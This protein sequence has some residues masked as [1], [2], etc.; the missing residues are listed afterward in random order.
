M[1]LVEPISKSGAGWPTIAFS[2]AVAVAAVM[3][4]PIVNLC[5]EPEIRFP[6]SLTAVGTYTAKR[7][8]N[9][10]RFEFRFARRRL[11]Q[12]SRVW[13]VEVDQFSAIIADSMIVPLSFPVVTT[14]AVAK[15]NLIHQPGLPQEPEG[16]V[17]SRITNRG[18][19]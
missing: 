13:Q 6:T 16:I 9:R 18:Q 7:Q 12:F 11:H 10:R 5:F 3:N 17:N 4:P 2:V 15:F 14:G 1:F 8:V 19:I